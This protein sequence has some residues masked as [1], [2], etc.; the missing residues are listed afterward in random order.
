MKF[1]VLSRDN[2]KNWKTDEKHIVISVYG[3]TDK[4]GPAILK[5]QD[6]RIDKLVLA[7]HD[8]DERTKDVV[9]KCPN[10]SLSKKLVFMSDQDAKD[11]VSFVRRYIDKV[12]LIVCQCDAGISRSSAIAAALSK[13]INGIDESYFIDY[14]PNMFIYTKIMKEWYE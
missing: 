12:D 8:I 5:D 7:F 9:E 3:P 13:C 11:I 1:I 6:S 14:L 10:S 4:D 2:I